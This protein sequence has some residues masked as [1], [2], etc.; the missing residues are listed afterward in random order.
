LTEIG[1]S[2]RSAKLL[3]ISSTFARSAAFQHRLSASWKI[4]DFDEASSSLK[5]VELFWL[6]VTID[7]ASSLDAK[8]N[9]AANTPFANPLHREDA[10]RHIQAGRNSAGENEV[11]PGSSR[12]RH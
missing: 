7:S 9:T 5:Y 12:N 11:R 10:N 3:P 6:N 8:G 4:V 1:H 2:P